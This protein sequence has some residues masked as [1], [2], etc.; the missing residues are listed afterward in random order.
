MKRGGKRVREGGQ[1]L[2]MHG[3]RKARQGERERLH[4]SNST[5]FSNQLH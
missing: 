4:S 1:E 2:Q 3:G 5:H